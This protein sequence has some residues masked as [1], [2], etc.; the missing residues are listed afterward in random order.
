M[1]SLLVAPALA[2]HIAV[3][4]PVLGDLVVRGAGDL[5]AE[6]TARVLDAA[7]PQLAACLEAAHARA[8]LEESGSLTL[9]LQVEAGAVVRAATVLRPARADLARCLRKRVKPLKFA[10][11]PTRNR[12][13]VTADWVAPPPPGQANYPYAVKRGRPPS[14]VKKVP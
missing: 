10:V 12:V 1:L 14:P 5:P 6:A 11:A 13:R 9:V 7:R 4:G 8:P 3:T 2:A